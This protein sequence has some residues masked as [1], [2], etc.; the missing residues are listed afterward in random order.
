MQGGR[1]ALAQRGYSLY[2]VT[3][4]EEILDALLTADR[5]SAETHAAVAR[6]LGAG[7]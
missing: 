1:A 2:A 4:L 5:I 7:A 3:T 6:Y